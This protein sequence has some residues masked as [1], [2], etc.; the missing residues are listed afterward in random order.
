MNNKELLEKKTREFKNDHGKSHVELGYPVVAVVEGSV[1]FSKSKDA[2]DKYKKNVTS[3]TKRFI[4]S[5]LVMAVSLCYGLIGSALGLSN[6]AI[7]LGLWVIFAMGLICNFYIEKKTSSYQYKSLNKD[8][9]VYNGPS[10]D[11]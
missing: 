7:V 8:I 3:S 9:L 10:W 11:N 1:V 5:M 6:L 4:F 2:L